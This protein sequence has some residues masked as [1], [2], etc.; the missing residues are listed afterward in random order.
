MASVIVAGRGEAD[1]RWA[2][3][4]SD[5]REDNDDMQAARDAGLL[6]KLHAAGLATR[7]GELLG[8]GWLCVA[9]A[10]ESDLDAD[11]SVIA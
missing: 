5:A 2:V 10:D 7:D 4:A 1:E 8:D 9:Q 11:P 6:D 3:N